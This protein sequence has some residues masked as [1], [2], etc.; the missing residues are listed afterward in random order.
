M[1][2]GI[3]VS[4]A[5]SL[6][7]YFWFSCRQARNGRAFGSP[8]LCRETRSGRTAGRHLHYAMGVET[9][10]ACDRRGR[11][12]VEKKLACPDDER[13]ELGNGVPSPRG[14]IINRGVVVAVFFWFWFL[15]RPATSG[16]L[17]LA[18]GKRILPQLVQLLGLRKRRL[19][20]LTEGFAKSR[21]AV[22]GGRLIW[23]YN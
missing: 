5:S 1:G 22:K 23:S 18:G 11:G 19:D 9:S 14:A 20:I 17:M 12:P 6:A 8:C 21:T 3:F 10:C 16:F 13:R 15:E 7:A 2:A 4:C